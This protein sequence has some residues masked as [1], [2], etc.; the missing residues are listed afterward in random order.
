M[1]FKSS[2]SDIPFINHKLNL[3][4]C[5]RKRKKRNDEKRKRNMYECCDVNKFCKDIAKKDIH[6]ILILK[7]NV[8]NLLLQ[9]HIIIIIIQKTVFK[10][11]MKYS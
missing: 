7:R 1:L 4:E 8:N 11:L 6:F 10:T 9:Q 2:Y 3:N 5:K